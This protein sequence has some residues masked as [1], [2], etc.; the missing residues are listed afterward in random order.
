MAKDLHSIF[1]KYLSALGK[2]EASA[3]ELT[4]NVRG[5]IV[6]NG[7]VVKEKLENQIEETASRMGFIKS[8]DLDALLLRIDELESR[9]A[10][11]SKVSKKKKSTEKKG[12]K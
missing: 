7:E 1:K 4:K 2:N 6:E 3:V 11:K 12:E 5:W 8:S 10:K 9:V